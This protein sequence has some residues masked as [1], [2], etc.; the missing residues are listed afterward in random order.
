MAVVSNPSPARLLSGG[1]AADE[2]VPNLCNEYRDYVRNSDSI[3]GHVVTGA[4]QVMF[5]Q[6]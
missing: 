6:T 4:E 1:E 3:S 5:W 2:S